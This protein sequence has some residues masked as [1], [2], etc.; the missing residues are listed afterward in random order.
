MRAFLLGRFQPP[1]RGHL[2][3][4]AHAARR[5]EVVYVGIGSSQVSHTPDNPFTTGERVQMLQAVL[6]RLRL[7]NVFLFPIT[8]L[9]DHPRWVRHVES[10]V[11]PFDLVITH[12]PLTR[13]LFRAA[14]Y[15]VQRGPLWNR[16]TWSGQEVRRRL[17]Q[18]EPVRALLPPPVWNELGK[19]GG[20]D[21]VRGLPEAVRAARRR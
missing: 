10:L 1:H 3:A 2:K 14:G 18:G 13:K 4:I 9:N 11:P 20:A 15:R 8:D 16:T 19:I 12:N 7:R 5:N 21:R 6:R 17:R